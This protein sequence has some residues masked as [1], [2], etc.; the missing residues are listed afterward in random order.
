MPSVLISY[1]VNR[2]ILLEANIPG[3]IL[4]DCSSLSTTTRPRRR[5]SQ[6]SRVSSFDPLGRVTRADYS[7]LLPLL[8]SN[9][10][11]EQLM[12]RK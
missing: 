8:A 2:D 3:L 12:Q 1:G 6:L 11:K 4:R 9:A 5:R 10:Q 7:G